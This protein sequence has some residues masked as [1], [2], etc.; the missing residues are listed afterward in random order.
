M[1]NFVVL[2]GNLVADQ[3]L[4]ELPSGQPVASFRMGTNERW[5]D[6]EGKRQ[7]RADFHQI[8]N[9]GQGAKNRDPYMNKGQ[10]VQVMGR[11]QHRS[12]EVNVEV[13]C[14]VPG[15]IEVEINGEKVMAKPTG[16][17]KGTAPITRWV[18]EVNARSVELLGK[19]NGSKR[20]EVQHIADA[21]SISIPDDDIPF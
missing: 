18:S 5:T 4:R 15:E 7:E 13:V 3:D 8:N 11:L 12:Y 17:I 9:F 16:P 6:R 21:E 1:G 2:T 14:T 10:L 19:S 20:Q